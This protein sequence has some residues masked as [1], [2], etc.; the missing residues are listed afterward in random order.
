MAGGGVPLAGRRQA[1]IDVGPAL[2]D[3]AEFQRR[4]DRD[5]LAAADRLLEIIGGR[6]VEVRL[7]RD[8]DQL[9]AALARRDGAPARPVLDP[10]PSPTSPPCSSR[11]PARNHAEA[12]QAVDDQPDV[13]RIIVAAA[14]EFLG[15]VERVDEEIG[16]AVGGNAAR[17]RLPPR[18][19]P[20]RPARPAPARAR[21]ISSAA[22]SASVTGERS[23]LLSTSKPRA[24]D[25]EDRLA[26]LPRRARRRRR[27]A[28]LVHRT[29]SAAPCGCR[30][31]AGPLRHSY[32][33]FRP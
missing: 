21:M 8:R 15:A 12:R 4:A 6:L 23:P 7:R 3:D 24:D 1:R 10:G 5:M 33:D 9:L 20:E 14:D 28:A 29:L 27:A 31:R 19:S 25:L 16:V 13:D 30:R 22:R 26:G 32:R 17:P 11:A 2:G 18:R